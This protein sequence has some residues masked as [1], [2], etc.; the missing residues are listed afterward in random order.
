MEPLKPEVMIRQVE[1]LAGDL[2]ALT[3]P[4]A[5]QIRTLLTP[6]EWR[7]VTKVYLTGDGDSYH[8]S[9]AAEMAFEA[10]AEVTGTPMSAQRF[11]DYGAAW[12]RQAVSHQTLVIAT[13]ASGGAK[14]VVQAIER[15][16]AHGALTVALTGMPNSAVTQAADRT[17]VV[18]LPHKERSP[19]IRTYQASLMGMLLIAIQLGAMRNTSSQTEADG[20]YQELITLADVVDATTDAIKERCREVA[21]LIADTPTLARLGSGPSYGTALFSAAKMVEAAGIF[22]IGQDLEEWW[23]V[24]RFAYPIYMPVFVIAPPGRSHWRAGDL[25]AT[26]HALGRRIIAVTHKDDTEVTRHAHVVLPVHGEVREEF[27]PLLYHLFASYVASYL[28]ARLGRSLFQSDRPELLQSVN[29]YY[30]SLQQDPAR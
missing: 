8:A 20:L 1:G 19:G 9:C 26:A 24:E 4:F 7:A 23:H 3:D 30:A 16:K 6:L 27:S 21:D 15:A 25:A 13:S 17:V 10:I 2:R 29:E 5:Q 14:R 18:E 12:I 11:L 22:A 28:A